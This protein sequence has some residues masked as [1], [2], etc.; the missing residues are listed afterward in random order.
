MQTVAC[1]L[2]TKSFCDLVRGKTAGCCS[3]F[4]KWS[5]VVYR[6]CFAAKGNQL[7]IP[8]PTTR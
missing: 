3:A 8:R 6:Q 5:A 2:R 1:V 7:P 4:V